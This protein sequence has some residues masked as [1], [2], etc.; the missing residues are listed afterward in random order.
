MPF[1][2]VIIPTYNRAH[3]L[4]NTI[5]SVLSQR[6][7]DFE[8]VIVD[9]GSKDDTDEVVRKYTSDKRVTYLKKENGERGAARNFGTSVASGQYVNF[10]DSD[11]L[12]YAN[13]LETARSFIEKLGSP[14]IFHVGYDY[15]A[16]NGELIYV[17]NKFDERSNDALLFDNILSCNG[18]FLRKDIANNYP[19]EENR[20]MASAEDWA[21]W[22]KLACRYKIK[23]CNE[24]TS[25]IVAHDERSIRTINI[26]KII[27]RDLFLIEHLKVDGKVFAYYGSRF[28]KFIAE[29]YTFFMLCLSE[30]K[31]KKQVAKWALKALFAYFPILFS[32]RFLASLKN[33]IR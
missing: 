9:D 16:P 1:F 31:E 8:L 6:F 20:V 32:K 3:L 5:E 21:L 7:N 2:S 26:E 24:V 23:F 25:A 17:R 14:E 30:R 11:D 33:T 4:R 19:F 13:H 12:M 28:N 15:K 27:L 29:R 22:T 18:V 10:F